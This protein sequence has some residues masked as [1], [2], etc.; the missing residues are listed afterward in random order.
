M[1]EK[2]SIYLYSDILQQVKFKLEEVGNLSEFSNKHNINYIVLHRI[3]NKPLTKE[4]PIILA[5]L[6][7]IL[8]GVHIAYT[9]LFL[10]TK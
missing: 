4:Y 10:R 7:F 3:K 1:K 8:Y 2:N 9:R 5:K 6:Y